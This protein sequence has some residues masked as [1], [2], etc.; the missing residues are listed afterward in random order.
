MS[1][2][3]DLQALQEKAEGS[4]HKEAFLVLEKSKHYRIGVGVRLPSSNHPSFF[5][6][7]LVYLCLN[8]SQVD[9]S[10]L[11]KKVNFLKELQGRTYVLICQQDGSIC[12]ELIISPKNLATEYE[13]INSI[14][15]RIFS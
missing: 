8:A 7:I 6:E 14:V 12:S 9:L 3:I 2:E 4:E 15:E 13:T 1:K 10:L 11:E 5:I